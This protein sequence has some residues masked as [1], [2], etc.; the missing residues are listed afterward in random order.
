MR[1]SHRRAGL[2]LSKK[3]Q[4]GNNHRLV[5]G[6]EHGERWRRARGHIPVTQCTAAVGL[7]VLLAFWERLRLVRRLARNQH[8]S[9]AMTC[10]ID[11]YR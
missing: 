5:S 2:V 7:M 3:T 4:W 8:A 6:D 10:V 9:S 11:F 1:L